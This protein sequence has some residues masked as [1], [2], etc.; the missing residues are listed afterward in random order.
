MRM[1][2]PQ[3]WLA[4]LAGSL[5]MAGCADVSEGEGGIAGSAMTQAVG[6]NTGESFATGAST[7]AV[8]NATTFV[9]AKHQA[10]ERQRRIAEER[11]RTAYQK[12]VAENRRR[13][14]AAAEVS[15]PQ[16]SGKKP[17]VAKRP[18]KP[19]K[20][21]RFI[22]V[23]TVKDERTAPKAKKSVMLWD[24][25]AERVVGNDVYDISTSPPVGSTARFETYS[26]QYVASGI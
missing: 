1:K 5:L 15:K 17:S 23:D 8:I 3:A 14:A 9:I 12:M 25:Q 7:G 22:A 2:L 13:E 4:V 11:A 26:A 6:M 20:L 21:P 16:T 24:T 10:T 18:P 19:A